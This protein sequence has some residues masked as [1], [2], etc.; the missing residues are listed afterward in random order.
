MREKEKKICIYKKKPQ[1]YLLQHALP[2]PKKRQT[3]TTI[4][5]RRD[6][7]D[8]THHLPPSDLKLSSFPSILPAHDLQPSVGYFRSLRKAKDETEPRIIVE[9]MNEL[10][11]DILWERTVGE[12]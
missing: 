5:L 8:I 4:I 1:T 9:T 6:R 11:A 12:K 2:G 10:G 3:N 7:R